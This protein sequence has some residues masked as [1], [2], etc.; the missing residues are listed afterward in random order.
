MRVE[1]N[2]STISVKTYLK[3]LTFVSQKCSWLFWERMCQ[4]LAGWFKSLKLE[5]ALDSH[6]SPRPPFFLD[7][8]GSTREWTIT[9]K[10]KIAWKKYFTYIHFFHL[11]GWQPY[12]GSIHRYEVWIGI[13]VSLV[14]TVLSYIFVL[15]HL[16]CFLND[17][18]STYCRFAKETRWK[19]KR[20]LLT[21]QQGRC[22]PRIVPT[23]PCIHNGHGCFC[24][25]YLS[26]A[27]ADTGCW[28][29]VTLW[30]FFFLF[31]VRFSEGSAENVISAKLE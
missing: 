22:Q 31:E 7:S 29:H 30:I 25:G 8:L 14:T 23:Y 28:G 9:Q 6:D 12:A 3:M 27:T 16:P 19:I 18:F 1:V 15:C 26:V 11:N 20:L 5:S 10:G 21:G 24:S 2:H 13:L 17:L 4:G